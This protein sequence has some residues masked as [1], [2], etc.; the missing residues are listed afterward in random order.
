M[1]YFPFFIDIS[2]K[3]GVIAGGTQAAADKVKKLLPFG[4]RLTVFAE[5]PEEEIKRLAAA[6]SSA[7]SLVKRHVTEK[8]LEDAAF[9]IT[10]LSD[11]NENA[12]IADWCQKRRI[13]INVADQPEYC[14]FYFPGIVKDGTVTV[15]ISTDGKSPAAAALLRQKVEEVMPEGIGN[16]AE[17][18]G[19]LRPQ[20]LLL[21]PDGKLRARIS[22]RMLAYCLEHADTVDEKQLRAYMHICIR[23]E[24][25]KGAR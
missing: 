9:V 22:K 5:A 19:Q 8:D 17:L 1:G 20:L 14:S 4:V 12:R 18:L 2:G 23:E 15:A 10:A 3:N 24:Q 7:V 16:A 13:L 21:V 6:H 11:K 25:E